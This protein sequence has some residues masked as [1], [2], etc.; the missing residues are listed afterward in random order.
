MHKIG[1]VIVLLQFL[2]LFCFYMK[3]SIGRRV[4]T[5]KACKNRSLDKEYVEIQRYPKV[6]VAR[7]DVSL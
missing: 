7:T 6:I 3:L 4:E 1:E 2:P 5:Q